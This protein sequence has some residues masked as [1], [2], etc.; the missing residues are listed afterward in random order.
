MSPLF[1]CRDAFANALEQ[2]AREQLNVVTVVNDSIG[3]S[4]IGNFAKLFPKRLVNVGI[5]ESGN[6]S[7]P[8]GIKTILRGK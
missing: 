4:K 3:S 1:D 2:V 5:A 6:D 7:T 8:R